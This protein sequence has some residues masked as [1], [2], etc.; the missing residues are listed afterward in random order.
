[1]KVLYDTVNKWAEKQHIEYQEVHI[2]TRLL[3]VRNGTYTRQF[4]RMT[5]HGTVR[6]LDD[7]GNEHLASYATC[8]HQRMEIMCLTREGEGFWQGIDARP[9]LRMRQTK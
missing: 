5:V 1:M 4:K 7:Q 3:G 8:L 9:F 2:P 6:V